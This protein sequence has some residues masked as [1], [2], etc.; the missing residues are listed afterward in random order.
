M[1]DDFHSLGLNATALPAGLLSKIWTSTLSV[2]P[3]I[4]V[5]IIVAPL[6]IVIATRYLSER[7]SVVVNDENERTVWMLPYYFPF[8]GHGFSL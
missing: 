2:P 8:V 6:A 4:L 3:S 1:D 5:A 7:P